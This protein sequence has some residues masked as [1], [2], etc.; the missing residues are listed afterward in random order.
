MQLPLRLMPHNFVSEVP[1]GEC[2]AGTCT[3]RKDF[4]VGDTIIT[5]A[6]KS[7]VVW[8]YGFADRQRRQHMDA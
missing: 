1:N 8:R 3:I 5:T 7:P 6:A 4:L 2:F